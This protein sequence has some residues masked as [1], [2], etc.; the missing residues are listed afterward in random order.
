MVI[1]LLRGAVATRADFPMEIS[2]RGGSLTIDEIAEDV[3]QL[4]FTNFND[5]SIS[6]LL[7]LINGSM[8]VSME[9][10]DPGLSYTINPGE[11]DFLPFGLGPHFLVYQ[12]PSAIGATLAVSGTVHGELD[13]SAARH[14]GFVH[15]TGTLRIEDPTARFLFIL[16]LGIEYEFDAKIF[17]SFSQW[18]VGAYEV[19]IFGEG[20][21]ITPFIVSFDGDGGASFPYRGHNCDVDLNRPI[22]D[23]LDDLGAG[24]PCSGF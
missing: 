3:F 11:D 15:E 6:Q 17:P 2:G 9:E 10:T 16:R 1:D 14:E 21:P 24:N 5:P 8:I 20:S 22:D 13:D 12:L 7:E 18:P 4:T 23:L 19:G